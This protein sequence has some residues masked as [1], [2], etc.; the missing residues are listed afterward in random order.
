MANQKATSLVAK[1]VKN[2]L[3][4]HISTRTCVDCGKPAKHYDHR[5][6]D[7]PLEVEPVCVKCNSAR[8]PAK[9]THIETYAKLTIVKSKKRFERVSLNL[10][11]TLKKQSIARAR[12]LDMTLPAL[13]RKLLRKEL[14]NK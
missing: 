3:L 6:Y 2:G 13:I 11:K 12:K 14:E 4:P 1:A 8:G 7:K 10:S 5:D 9:G